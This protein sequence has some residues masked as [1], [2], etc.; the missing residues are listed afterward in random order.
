MNGEHLYDGHD[1]ATGLH[2]SVYFCTE[3][4]REVAELRRSKK[5]SH[6]VA[7][8]LSSDTPVEIVKEVADW[9]K[10]QFIRVCRYEKKPGYILM[11]LDESKYAFKKAQEL[12]DVLKEKYP[13]LKV[14]VTGIEIDG[15]SGSLEE[16][17]ETLSE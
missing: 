16:L 7:L 15:D 13:G 17:A 6:L 4:E 5:N 9:W 10:E 2:D 3:L 14:D 8:T 11:G 1:K 12:S